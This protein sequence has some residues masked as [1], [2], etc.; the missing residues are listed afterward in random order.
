VHQG[1]AL[2]ENDFSLLD[3]FKGGS[4]EAVLGILWSGTDAKCR[5]SAGRTLL[6]MACARRDDW[7]VAQAI[8]RQILLC[9]ASVS[10]VNAEKMTALHYAAYL[11][12]CDVVRLL[13]D[14]NADVGALD[15]DYLSP[16]H[17]CLFRSD[18]ESANIAQLLL[19]RSRGVGVEQRYRRRMGHT[20]LLRACWK[21]TAAQV[22]VLLSFRA[23]VNALDYQK[24]ATPLMWALYNAE[25]G[26]EIIPI[27]IQAGKEGA[28]FGSLLFVQSSLQ[29]AT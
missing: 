10:Q 4:L 22:Q 26:H 21:G 28:F 19:A 18:V 16:L 23:D 8:V 12:S 9:G 5:D 2:A 3:T 7:Q 20:P 11:S 24:R 17:W 6:M 25:H 14:S 29:E 13:L 1:D 15:I 27:L